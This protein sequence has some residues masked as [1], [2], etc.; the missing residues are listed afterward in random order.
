LG[1]NETIY[2]RFDTSENGWD[3]SLIDVNEKAKQRLDQTWANHFNKNVPAAKR[4]DR[5]KPNAFNHTKYAKLYH[6]YSYMGLGWHDP[7][8][9]FMPDPTERLLRALP[10]IFG[11]K[12]KKLNGDTF[13]E[14]LAESCPELDG[15]KLFLEANK[16]QEDTIVQ[17]QCTLGLSQALVGLH[18]DK[19]LL[20]VCPR[21]STGW[22]IGRADPARDD[23]IEGDRITQVKLA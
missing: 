9:Q 10:S 16:Y 21:D 19:V 2:D 13:M 15:G 4:S 23:T 18:E 20:L 14:K 22:N 12:E 6:W 8:G 11:P 7:R 3:P 1:L 17:K 5:D